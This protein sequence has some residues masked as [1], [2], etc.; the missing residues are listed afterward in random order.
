MDILEHVAEIFSDHERDGG[1]PLVLGVFDLEVG[2]ELVE[3]DVGVAGFVFVL[4]VEDV[5]GRLVDLFVDFEVLG[6]DVGS[7]FTV[8]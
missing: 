4:V 6:L 8:K 2:E 3:E 7:H 5:E 1:Y